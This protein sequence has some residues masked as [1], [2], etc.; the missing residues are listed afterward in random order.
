MHTYTAFSDVVPSR[1]RC[2]QR[3]SKPCTL[4][5]SFEIAEHAYLPPIIPSWKAGLLAVNADSSRTNVATSEY[6]F[7]K[8]ELFVSVQTPEKQKVVLLAWLRLRVGL[9]ALLAPPFNLPVLPHQ[10]WQTLLQFD[11]LQNPANHDPA[12]SQFN[13]REAKRQE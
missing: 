12:S 9:I 13:D 1:G 11:W 8:P 2:G 3:A 4:P 6:A 10:T 7:P 5:T